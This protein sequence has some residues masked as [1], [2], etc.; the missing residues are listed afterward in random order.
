MTET[1]ALSIRIYEERGLGSP[2]LSL[3]VL[4]LS[5]LI[6]NLH[7]TDSNWH[8]G[9]MIVQAM[10]ALSHPT[11]DGSF[12]RLP[13]VI[14]ILLA[15]YIA[16]KES[17][18][19]PSQ[20]VYRIAINKIIIVLERLNGIAISS[21]SNLNSPQNVYVTAARMEIPTSRLLDSMHKLRQSI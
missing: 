6:N 14:D 8:E 3:P 12:K 20:G 2:Y 18:Q 11:S 17:A 15:A 10:C 16:E 4:D 7:I 5:K 13:H 19:V 1:E 9:L 21:T